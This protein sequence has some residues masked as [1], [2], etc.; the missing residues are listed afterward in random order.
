MVSQYLFFTDKNRI[1]L[2]EISIHTKLQLVTRSRGYIGCV[3]KC[4]SEAKIE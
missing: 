3:K 1:K 4:L 2:F